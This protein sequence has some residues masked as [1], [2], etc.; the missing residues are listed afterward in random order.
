MANIG[1]SSDW[2]KI[3]LGVKATERLIG[4]KNYNAA[5]VKALQT[6]EYMVELLLERACI[7][8]GGDLK[9]SID[10]LYE[11]R[12]INKT[13]YEHYHKIRTIGSK[14]SQENDNNAYNANQA[15]HML[16]QEVYT[17]ANDYR[18]A[19]KGVRR[20]SASSASSAPSGQS[21]SR[22]RSS[23]KRSGLTM[24]DLL[25]L[26]IPVLCVILLICVIKLVKPEEDSSDAAET[27][28]TAE[29][30]QPESIPEQMP[31]T[32][33]PVA[34]YKTTSVLN[35]RSQPST[36]AERIG[37]LQAGVAVEYVDEYNDEWSIILYQGQ[38][39]YVASQY[40]T[41]E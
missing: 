10:T 22:K 2:E 25:K 3:Q 16:S 8:D 40:L 35:V 28:S 31:E 37:Q 13:T 29:A 19:Q 17:F 32:D 1:S 21:R 23:K 6:L 12:W 24:H 11:T 36:D 4:Q 33:S 20:T 5:M 7:P 26:L 34:V 27:S 15:Y 38:E 14:A 18:G 9:V 30:I 41:I 39:A